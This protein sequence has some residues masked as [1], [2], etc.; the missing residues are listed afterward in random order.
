MTRAPDEI[1]GGLCVFRLRNNCRNILICRG[2]LG[3]QWRGLPTERHMARL[4][5]L[6]VIGVHEREE[7]ERFFGKM[8]V[9]FRNQKNRGVHHPFDSWGCPQTLRPPFP[10]NQWIEVTV[11]GFRHRAASPPLAQRPAAS[12][13]RPRRTWRSSSGRWGPPG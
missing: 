10:S 7:R 9:V 11:Q 13:P 5:F 8:L 6:G 3:Y 4:T 2:S 12:A 1:V